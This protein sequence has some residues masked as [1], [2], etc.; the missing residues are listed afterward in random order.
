MVADTVV[1]GTGT[2]EADEDTK[3]AAPAV[4]WTAPPAGTPVN[5]ARPSAAVVTDEPPAWV[6]VAPEIG[7]PLV[8]LLTVMVT[9]PTWPLE[10]VPPVC[11]TPTG[12]R[13]KKVGLEGLLSNRHLT[14]KVEVCTCEGSN[15]FTVSSRI[16]LIWNS[17]GARLPPPNPVAVLKSTASPD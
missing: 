8:A 5:V 3:P 9:V 14:L 15:G 13:C 11:T 17:S 1:L 12:M 16:P 7:W 2:I 10:P 6:T 4:N